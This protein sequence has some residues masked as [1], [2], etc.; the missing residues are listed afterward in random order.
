MSTTRLSTHGRSTQDKGRVYDFAGIGVGPFNLGLAAL[1][2]PIEGL[3]GVFLERR[4]SFDWHPGMMLE[5]AHLQVPFMA[6]LVTLADPT[7]PYSF[8]EFP[9]ADRADLPL[10]HPRKLLPPAG[11]VQPVLPVGG[12]PAAF[13]PVWR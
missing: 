12:R 11:R 4:E 6:D 10:L 1:S 2:Q 9:Q 3:D 13:G 7:S 5:P 8:P